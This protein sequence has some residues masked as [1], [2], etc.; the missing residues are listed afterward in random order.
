M[1]P[2]PADAVAE[3]GSSAPGRS[4]RI[5][6]AATDITKKKA[7][8]MIARTR[9]TFGRLAGVG[10]LLGTL[11]ALPL[12]AAA[13][14]APARTDQAEKATI[15]F[16][17]ID[18]GLAARPGPMD[19][20]SGGGERTLRDTVALLESAAK[21]ADTT[22]IL[23][24]LKDPELN[25]TQVEELSQAIASARK[26]G[27][28]VHLYAEMYGPA[29]L[30]LGAGTDEVI[31]QS[32]GAVSFPGIYMTEMYFA[33][34]LAWA[35]VRADMVQV[36]DYKGASEAMARNAPSPQ[37]NENIEGLLDGLYG[38]MR[39]SIKSGRGMD[40]A[41]LDKAMEQA[42]MAMGD[43]A[44]AAGL[45]DAELDWPELSGHLART[46]GADVA[47]KT[48]GEKSGRAKADASNPFAIFSALSKT[49]DH[50]PKRSTI[51]LVHIDGAIVD[52]DSKAGGLGGSASVGS[53]TIRRAL[54]DIEAS[55]LIKGVVLRIESPGGSAIASEVIWHGVKR[56]AAKKPVWV[57]VGNMAASGGYYIAVS[58]D[59]IY[60]NPSSIVGSIGVVGGK[61]VMGG[62]LEKLNV[63]VVG[64]GRGPMAGMLNPTTAWTDS[65][66]AMIRGKMAE[67][68]DLF[69][70]RVKAGRDG[71]DLART[72]EGRLFAGHRA[73]ELKMAD[74]VGTLRD[75]VRD[76]AAELKLA[77]GQYD[78][79]DYPGPMSFEEMIQEMLGGFLA[80]APRG[81]ARAGGVLTELP[82]LME[83]T[84]GEGA[85][86]QVR[87]HL[88]A[89][90]QLRDEPVL[91]VGP[92]VII[93]R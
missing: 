32:G 69:T 85:W 34:A 31:L 60:V 11:T 92:R 42:W 87:E 21:S 30:M 15:A 84:L 65:E 55:D 63:N 45:I 70:A 66:R 89:L 75:A 5:G 2:T 90:M 44:K 20:L 26:A 27:K 14:T 16:L 1:Q 47:W 35:G 61:V 56:V 33:D 53:R 73:V 88:S 93:I 43:D 46:Y 3:Q 80:T 52:G 62:L 50:T 24:R 22:A 7:R 48:L 4:R 23:I 54:A 12:A 41:K 51:A 29:E 57:S 59:R 81:G 58:G 83:Q 17:E 36:G 79:M 49:P 40:D 86:R 91:L 82:L 72:A 64:R 19:W 6:T 25:S 78:V 8:T 71:I 18:G 13:G 37:W 39:S 38:A 68:Y 10:V 77:D 9:S 67:I 28:K 76:L 74:R